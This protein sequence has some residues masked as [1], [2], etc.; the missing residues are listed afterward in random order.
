MRLYEN[1]AM[2]VDVIELRQGDQARDPAAVRAT[3]PVRGQVSIDRLLSHQ[4]MD[5][6]P[7]HADI[8]PMVLETLYAARIEYWRGLNIV[9]A[10]RQRQQIPGRKRAEAVFEQRWWLRLVL[11]PSEPPIAPVNRRRQRTVHQASGG[12]MAVEKS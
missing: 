3:V 4:H 11:D 12:L 9:L 1:T 10:G 2:L 8:R 6:A 5:R 7:V